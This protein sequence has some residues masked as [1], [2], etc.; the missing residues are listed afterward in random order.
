MRIVKIAS[1]IFVVQLM[2]MASSQ[3]QQIFAAPVPPQIVTAKKVFI[4]NG[5]RDSSVA[6][7]LYTAE[8]YR[9][10]NQL[11]GAV[12]KSGRFELVATPQDADLVLEI[13]TKV[14]VGAPSRLLL[15]IFEARTHYVLWKMDSWIELAMRQ[16]TRDHNFDVAVNRLSSDL[17]KLAAPQH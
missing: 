9:A 5:G 10:F 15:T 13:S 3:A 7:D 16:P 8:P 12:Q 2:A 1:F 6:A 4:A 14:A 11:Y 17:E